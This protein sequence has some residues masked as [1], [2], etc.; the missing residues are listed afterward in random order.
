[1]E[2]ITVNYQNC[3]APVITV[4]NP[5]TNGTTV[6]NENFNYSATILNSNNGQGITL[7]LNNAPITNFSFNNATGV[8]QSAVL[9]TQGLNTFVVTSVNNCGTDVETSTIIYQKCIAPMITVVA[10]TSNGTTVT[11][12]SFSLNA[13][14]VNSNN[15]QGITLKQN[16]VTVTNFSF[17]NA[18][19]SFHPKYGYTCSWIKYIRVDFS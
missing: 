19:N 3:I 1:V 11:S 4:T 8:I 15:G 5:V 2:T 10:P 12:A 7:T 6:L 16:N 13:T 14:I 17:N 9:L 18:T